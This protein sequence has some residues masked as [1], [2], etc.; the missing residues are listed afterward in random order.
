MS[1]TAIL[2]WVKIILGG[3]VGFGL[4]SVADS[5]MLQGALDEFLGACV[6]LVG[7]I[8]LILRNLT[9][10]ALGKWWGGK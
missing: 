3:L 10:S 5:E 7:A 2:A 8:D 1:K 6:V 9:N 4:I